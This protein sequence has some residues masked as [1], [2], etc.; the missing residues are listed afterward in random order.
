[1]TSPLV[2]SATHH[3]TR[4]GL[5]LVVSEQKTWL[6]AGLQ[7]GGVEH[8]SPRLKVNLAARSIRAPVIETHCDA[9]AYTLHL[10]TETLLTSKRIISL[11][12]GS[13]DDKASHK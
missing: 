3:Q 13:I 2:S 7:N 9:R 4:L 8:S 6:Q 12:N 1:M 5:T 10:R 11:F